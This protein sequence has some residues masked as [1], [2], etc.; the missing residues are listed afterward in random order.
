MLLADTSVIGTV[1]DPATRAA[2]DAAK[3]IGVPEI[4]TA[5]EPGAIVC[6]PK[7]RFTPEP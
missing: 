1:D 2:P 6:V 7:T 5:G 3:E 4:S